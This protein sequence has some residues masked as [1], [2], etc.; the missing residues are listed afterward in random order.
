MNRKKDWIS[1]CFC[2]LNAFIVKTTNNDYHGVLFCLT[3]IVHHPKNFLKLAIHDTNQYAWPIFIQQFFLFIFLIY[4]VG[5]K[6]RK[7]NLVDK[8]GQAYWLKAWIGNFRKFFGWCTTV[9]K[10]KKYTM[11]V[12]I[13]GFYSKSVIF[14][15]FAPKKKHFQHYKSWSG[16]DSSIEFFFQIFPNYQGMCQCAAKPKNIFGSGPFWYICVRNPCANPPKNTS[17]T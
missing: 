11:V 7:E 16:H 14:P 2:F 15:F 8:L 12:I 3:T 9:V 6:K 13:C 10:Q 17:T 4:T 1:S 5:K